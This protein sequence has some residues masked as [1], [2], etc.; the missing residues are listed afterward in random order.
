MF[1]RDNILIHF[2]SLIEK[3]KKKEKV[4]NLKIS[5]AL[6]SETKLSTS[7]QKDFLEKQLLHFRKI[8]NFKYT[9]FSLL[10]LSEIY[11]D[12]KLPNVTLLDELEE[13]SKNDYYLRNYFF[14][15]YILILI[16]E[17]DLEL[18]KEKALSYLSFLD[19]NKLNERII[20]LV[21][22]LDEKIRLEDWLYSFWLKALGRTGDLEEFIKIF[23]RYKR[24]FLLDH[25]SLPSWYSSL[26]EL[27]EKKGVNWWLYSETYLNK[28]VLDLNHTGVNNTI[29]DCHNLLT[30]FHRYFV[31][32]GFDGVSYGYFSRKIKSKYKGFGVDFEV[33]KKSKEDNS[34][35]TKVLDRDNLFLEK[36][37]ISSDIR[38]ESFNKFNNSIDL[39]Q[40]F[41]TGEKK[42]LVFLKKIPFEKI[43][44]N[45]FDWLICFIQMK[46]FSILDYL[47]F[48]LESN[49]RFSALNIKN[50]LEYEYLVCEIYNLKEDWE[51]LLVRSLNILQSYNLLESDYL[52]IYYLKGEA[53]WNM[54]RLK[55][56]KQVFLEIQGMNPSFRIV[57]QRLED[58]GKNK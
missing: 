10:A 42:L 8:S 29:L 5:H 41:I 39:N 46:A 38:N 27:W 14:I 7:E 55:E 22:Q 34:N 13:L 3:I 57:T 11:S 52:P 30:S 26:Q 25:S 53:L 23:N 56:A 12:L 51:K 32:F 4:F 58:I 2:D 21:S 17:G 6:F 49:N 20:Y 35:S 48:S 44:K 47:I 40:E 15:E 9:F 33:I 43:E 16:E 28:L 37:L 31:I 1:C 45:I 50:K 18:A 24:S 54:G 36:E 19:T